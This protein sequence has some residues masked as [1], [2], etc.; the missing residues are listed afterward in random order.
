MSRWFY[1]MS[2]STWPSENY[3]RE[4]REGRSVRWPTRR[5]MFKTGPPAAGDLIVCFYAPSGSEKAGIC[6]IGLITK[7]LPK[8][9][10]FDW[11]PLPPTDALKR[12]PWWDDRVKEISE[13]IRAQSPR[14]TMYSLPAALDT[15]IR[16]GAFAC[17]QP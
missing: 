17:V 10:K 14:G 16:R 7:Y 9:R 15:D 13:L 3:R 12:E 5:Q 11:L 2:E 6:G 1:Q 8:T 4:V